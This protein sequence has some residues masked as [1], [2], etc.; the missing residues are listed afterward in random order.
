MATNRIFPATNGPTSPSGSAGNFISGVVFCVTGEAWFEGYWWWVCPTGQSTSSIKCALWQIPMTNSITP[1]L[2]PNSIVTSGALTAGQWNFIPLAN[3]IPLSL[4]GSSGMTPP[5]TGQGGGQY[6]AAVGSG[7][8]FPDTNNYWGAAQPGA[9]GITSGPLTA[10]SGPSASMPAPYQSW[11]QGCFSVASSDPSV[12]CPNQASGTDNFWVDVQVADYSAA[13]VGSSLRLWPNLP[14]P[15]LTANNDNTIAVSGTAFVLTRPCKLNRIWMYSPSGSTGLPS[16]VGVWSVS[17][18]TEVAGTDNAS[19]SW[20]GAA[21][22][23]WISV[24]YSGLSVT[25]PAGTYIVAYFNGSGVK[26]YFDTPN[27]FFAGTDPKGGGTVGGPGWNGISRGGGVLTS[28]NVAN[29]PS[30]VYDDSSGIHPGQCCYQPG[31]TAWQYPSEFEASADWG[32]TRWAD[33]EVIP[34]SINSGAL[35]AVMP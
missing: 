27:F 26:C 30:L 33:L 8:P 3:P 35:L 9:S 25:I 2:V 31:N 29:G 10:F 15:A 12:A 6:V 17:S 22:S 7:Q 19:P 28:P 1:Q 24:D 34:L 16:R 23:G 20:S 18:Q 21:G 14:A 32:E 11:P 4:G 5:I 13:P